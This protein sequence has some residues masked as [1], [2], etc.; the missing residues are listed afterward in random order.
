MLEVYHPA[1]QM[2]IAAH[3]E[4]HTPCLPFF[5][6]STKLVDAPPADFL[7]GVK[8]WTIQGRIIGGPVP[9]TSECG[10]TG[11]SH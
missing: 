3:K 2:K 1:Q 5:L 7:I 9:E 8:M 11:K 6:E 10:H 4:F